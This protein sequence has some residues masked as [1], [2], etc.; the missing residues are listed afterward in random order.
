VCGGSG[1]FLLKHA[2]S[3]LADAYITS[4]FKYHEFFDVEQ[5]LLLIDTGHFESEQF[6]PEIFYDIIKNKFNTFA[7][8][9]SKINTNPVN[10]F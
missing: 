1:Q 7:V 4:D 9:L 6:T 10:Y 8:R 2:I 3:S 5:K